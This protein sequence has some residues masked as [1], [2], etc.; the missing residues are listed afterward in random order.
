M[1]VLTLTLRYHIVSNG[2]G[3]KSHLVNIGQ[4]TVWVVVFYYLARVCWTS[5]ES[6]VMATEAYP[7][8]L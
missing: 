8:V 5:T 2:V 6:Y 3:S 4:S 1:G 7:Q